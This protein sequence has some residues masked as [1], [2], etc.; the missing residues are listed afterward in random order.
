MRALFSD[1]AS[2]GPAVGSR[3]LLLWARLRRTRTGPILMRTIATVAALAAL[4]I[5]SPASP[6]APLEPIDGALFTMAAAGVGLFPRTWWPTFLALAVAGS[7]LANTLDADPV[8]LLRLGALM[9]ALYLMHS[10]AAMAAVLPYDCA[11]A[12]AVLVRW[13]LRVFGV[14]AGGLALGLGGVVLTSF[15]PAAPHLIGPVAG[16]VIATALVSLFVWQLRRS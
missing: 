2:F 3:L 5:S 10:S 4:L 12:P 1:P 9:A 16:A 8:P 11:I 7:W 6:S 15:V 13:A 14:L